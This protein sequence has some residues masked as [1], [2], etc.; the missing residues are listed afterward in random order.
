[1]IV[2]LLSRTSIQQVASFELLGS[3]RNGD[4]LQ[5]RVSGMVDRGVARL[6]ILDQVLDVDT[7][8]DLPEGAVIEVVVE[9]DGPRLKLLFKPEVVQ[10]AKP[11]GIELADDAETLRLAANRAAPPGASIRAA[12]ISSGI[13]D[14]P[15]ITPPPVPVH[16]GV[17]DHD[18]SPVQSRV[19]TAYAPDESA[20]IDTE[21][22]ISA[23]DIATA[24]TGHVQQPNASKSEPPPPPIAS[25][26][27]TSA[28]PTAAH[29]LPEP[30]EPAKPGLRYFDDA[31]GETGPAE[32]SLWLHGPVSIDWTMD[33]GPL[34]VLAI[35]ASLGKEGAGISF[36][37]NAAQG[38]TALE[39]ALHKLDEALRAAGIPV[40]RLAVSHGPVEHSN[41]SPNA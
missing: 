24:D 38:A 4:V 1:M 23:R 28:Q 13:R 41:V 5:A 20:S 9:R 2:E 12:L 36:R 15:Q 40:D 16:A 34:G 35:R 37:S 21:P 33:A 10:G 27:D 8:R 31:D 25:A 39:A 26:P 32:P 6:Q 3:L 17:L 30:P 19:R 11:G 14:A 22:R 18:P 29:R 7:P